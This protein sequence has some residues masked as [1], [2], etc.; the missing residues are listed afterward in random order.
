MNLAFA[1][2]IIPVKINTL[3]CNYKNMPSQIFE[4]QGI[5]L[6]S[7]RTLT[8]NLG[9]QQILSTNLTVEIPI[10]FYGK[11]YSPKNFSCFKFQVTPSKY[12]LSWKK[13]APILKVRRFQ[14]HIKPKSKVLTLANNNHNSKLYL[15]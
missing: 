1:D 7:S 14:I 15:C 9:N 13:L 2:G 6:K 10:G 8:I 3:S 5:L 11:V 12:F 4:Y